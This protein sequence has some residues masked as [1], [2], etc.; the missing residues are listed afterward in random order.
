LTSF[1]YT[2]TQLSKHLLASILASVV[3][4]LP[5]TGAGLVIPLVV[6]AFLADSHLIDDQ[7]DFK[8]FSKSFA[9]AR[10]LRDILI[11][12]TVDS[13]IQVGN[14]THGAENVFLSC[15]KGKKKGLS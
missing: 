15:D 8:L 3:L 6:A 11:S 10:N 4:G 5:L 2:G 1:I 12:F 7:I 9:L 13:L 14:Q